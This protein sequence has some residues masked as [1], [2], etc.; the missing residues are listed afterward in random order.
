VAHALGGSVEALVTPMQFS[1]GMFRAMS[2]VAGVVIACAGAIGVTPVAVVRR[3]VAPMAV[4][5]VV[6]FVAN[7]LLVS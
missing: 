4:G 3:T 7:F 2:P 6:M 5:F 1:A